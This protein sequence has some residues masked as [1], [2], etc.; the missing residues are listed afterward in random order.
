VHSV[1]KKT[2]S[3]KLDDSKVFKVAQ[4]LN[5]DVDANASA[6]DVK[7]ALEAFLAQL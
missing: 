7:K 2:M 1:E 3:I 5:I 6:K 4:L